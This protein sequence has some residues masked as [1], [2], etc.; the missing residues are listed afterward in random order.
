MGRSTRRLRCEGL[1]AQ[2]WA[3]IGCDGMR[4]GVFDGV[5]RRAPGMERSEADA[6]AG[7]FEGVLYDNAQPQRSA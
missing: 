6:Q 5:R 1:D 4:L 7:D 3:A 2:R